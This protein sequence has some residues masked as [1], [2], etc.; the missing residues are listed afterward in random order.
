MNYRMKGI[1]RHRLYLAIKGKFKGGSAVRDLG[2]SIEFFLQYIEDR[3]KSP[4]SWDNWGKIWEID[5]IIS[6]SHFNLSNRDELLKACHYTNQQPL[7]KTTRIAREHGDMISV[8]NS[9]KSDKLLICASE[10]TR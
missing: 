7:W 10:S 1:L 8:G 2:C 5:H 3:F 4:M 6:L 9:E